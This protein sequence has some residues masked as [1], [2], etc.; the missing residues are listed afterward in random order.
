NNLVLFALLILGGCI[1]NSIICASF[2]M[3]EHRYLARLIWL[4]PMAASVF[5]WKMIL[6]K[7]QPTPRND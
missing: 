4:I 5:V 1:I 6:V 3:A 7:N 2:A